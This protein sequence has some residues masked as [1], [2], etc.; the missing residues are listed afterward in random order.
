MCHTIKLYFWIQVRTFIFLFCYLWSVHWHSYYISTN[1]LFPSISFTIWFSFKIGTFSCIIPFATIAPSLTCARQ[2]V[3]FVF[4]FCCWWSACCHSYY[5]STNISFPSISIMIWFLFKRDI[6][7]CAIPFATFEPTHMCQSSWD[8][9]FSVLLLGNGLN[10]V[11]HTCGGINSTNILL[12]SI[13][14]KR[15]S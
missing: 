10:A 14:F 12:P 6:L 8:S 7:S 13:F 3:T 9:H 5:T 11:A 15:Y 1:I 4:L 2:V